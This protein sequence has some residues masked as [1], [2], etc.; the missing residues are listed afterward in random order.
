LF[1]RG[2]G[3]Y[4]APKILF[5]GKNFK[6]FFPQIFPEYFFSFFL[7]ICYFTAAAFSHFLGTNSKKYFCA[8]TILENIFLEKNMFLN[9]LFPKSG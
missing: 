2:G 1:S 6:I 8:K 5:F 3:N 7:L 4:Q 9:V